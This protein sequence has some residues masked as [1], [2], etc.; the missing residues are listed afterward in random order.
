[1]CDHHCRGRKVVQ[2]RPPEAHGERWVKEGDGKSEEAWGSTERRRRDV[3]AALR[4]NAG[5]TKIATARRKR[6]R[7][8][9]D[10]RAKRDAEEKP[11]SEQPT[12]MVISSKWK[13]KPLFSL[14]RAR[15]SS[16]Q[17]CTPARTAAFP[18]C[19]SEF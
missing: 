5:R 12:V 2:R 16:R 1:M 19:V 8:T 17:I 10:E 15:A 6:W 13:R 9:R 7:V 18:R 4:R 14:P 11:S 3:R